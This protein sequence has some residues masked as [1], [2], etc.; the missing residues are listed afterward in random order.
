MLKLHL[1]CREN[2]VETDIAGDK[3]IFRK[4]FW[5]DFFDHHR[6][7]VGDR[8][9]LERLSEFEYRVYPWVDRDAGR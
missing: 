3:K 2:P 9:A 7:E 8:I 1:C 5:R 6:L 4:R